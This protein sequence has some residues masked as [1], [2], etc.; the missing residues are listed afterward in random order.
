MGDQDMED[1]VASAEVSGDMPTILIIDDSAAMRRGMGAL[2]ADM[3]LEV[4]TLFAKDGLVGFSMA[5]QHPV[6][7]I[8]CDLHMPICDG[9]ALL[10]LV[11]NDSALRDIPVVMLTASDDADGVVAALEAGAVDYVRKPALPAELRARISVHLRLKQ[12]SD[13]LRQRT[14]EL[15]TLAHTDGLTQVENRRSLDE[16]LQAEH[17]RALRYDRPLSVLMLDVDHFKKLNDTH[18]HQAGDLMLQA[19]AT[20]LKSTVRTNDLVARYGGEEFAVVLPETPLVPAAH[21]ARRLR[22]A[23]EALR[24]D[25]DGKQLRMTVSVGVAACTPGQAADGVKLMAAADAALYRAKTGGRNRVE[26]AETH[27]TQAPKLA[28]ATPLAS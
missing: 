19:L 8:L 22:I 17:A 26:L 18:G 25:C 1:C 15:K 12:L 2:L 16:I 11:R 23:V 3:G 27:S 24:V 20:M 6:D 13:Q 10:R 9:M 14:A 5:R 7:L 21:L 4:R 28:A